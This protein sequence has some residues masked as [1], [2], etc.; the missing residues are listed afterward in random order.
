MKTK[1]S[2]LL[3]ALFFL[4]GCAGTGSPKKEAQDAGKRAKIQQ[5]KADKAF[6]ELD[7][8]FDESGEIKEPELT[9]S[10]DAAP[11]PQ[12]LPE[13][14]DYSSSR[15][16]K[17]TGMGQSDAEA[18]RMAKAELSN[19]FESKIS[20]EVLT[21]AKAFTDISGG[22]KFKKS[23]EHNISVISAVQLKGVQIGKT[24]YDK[25]SRVYYAEAV[26]DRYKAR[27]QWNGDIEKID[28]VIKAEFKNFSN[29]PSPV[30]H[31]IPIRKILKLWIEKEVL[32][33]RLKVIG[34]P[35]PGF[36]DYN[37]KNLIEMIPQ[38]RS[39]IRIYIAMEGDYAR[40]IE[41][42]ISRTL[43]GEGFNIS[44]MRNGA[45]VLV[46]GRVETEPVRLNNPDFKFV[47]ARVSLAVTDLSSG[48]KVGDVSS[49]VRKGHISIKEAE[50][51]AIQSVSKSVSKEL[52]KQFSFEGLID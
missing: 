25:K 19:I 27:E 49:N 1:F 35:E 20:S 33:S 12:S 41:N 47:R 16:L 43:T 50:H 7:R 31:L 38:I 44:N 14:V 24:W 48:T 40:Q 30:S 42:A 15:Y 8:G 46:A 39:K 5:E 51:K 10:P 6:D 23:I 29:L 32:V 4:V 13:N 34:F 21:S 45:D 2:L 22:E 26:L 52:I 17:A 37:I 36:S 28:T 11:S 9:G 3:V 18:R